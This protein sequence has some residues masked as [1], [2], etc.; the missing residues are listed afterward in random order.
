[1]EQISEFLSKIGWYLQH[2]GCEHYYFYNHKKECTGMYLI[3]PKTDARICIEPKES[4]M[5]NITFYVKQVSME[6]LDGDDTVAFAAKDNDS[7]FILCHNF[8]RK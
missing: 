8:D 3:F 1:M 7:V 4:G 6:L 2:H 5:P